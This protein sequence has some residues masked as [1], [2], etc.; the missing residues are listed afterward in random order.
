MKIWLVLKSI[1][2]RF[3]PKPVCACT[4]W[5][6]ISVI[7][8]LISSFSY[9]CGPFS[10]FC[11]SWS[12]FLSLSFSSS[13]SLIILSVSDWLTTGWSLIILA[14]LAYLSVDKVS[15]IL[16]HE[17]EIVHSIV[18]LEFPPKAFCSSHVRAESL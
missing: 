7:W 1:L 11:S 17:G 14:W 10:F 8:F 2:E 13:S 16:S 15:S 4:I 18:V 3:S 12:I 5:D 9:S 6:C